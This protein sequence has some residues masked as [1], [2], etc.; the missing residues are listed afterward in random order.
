MSHHRL[1]RSAAIGLALAALTA[2]TAAAQQQDF[3]TP[4]ARDA[5]SV[6]Q[7]PPDLRSPDTRDAAAGRG[8]FNAPQVIVIKVPQ[9]TPSA[10]GMDWGDAGIGAGALLALIALGVGGSIAVVRRRHARTTRR[11]TATTG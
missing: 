3:R 2:P 5:V 11:Q 8:T 1:T 4:D 10:G 6:G 9:S 7:T